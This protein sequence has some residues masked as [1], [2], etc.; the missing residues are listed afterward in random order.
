MPRPSRRLWVGVGL[1]VAL[2]ALAA[3]Q[4]SRLAPHEEPA[5]GSVDTQQPGSPWTWNGTD[6]TQLAATGSGPHSS[7]AD[8]AYD[9]GR[10]VLVLWDPPASGRVRERDRAGVGLERVRLDRP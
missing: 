6:Y 5:Y 8:M 4:S 7:S 2:L 1:L 3:W 10:N 9:E